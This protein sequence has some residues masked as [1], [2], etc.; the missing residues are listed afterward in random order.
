VY[1][2]ELT[3]PDGTD[4]TAN[5]PQKQTKKLRYRFENKASI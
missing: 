3:G 1:M 2:S 4:N 5:C